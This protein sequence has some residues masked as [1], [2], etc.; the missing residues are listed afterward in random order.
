MIIESVSEHY[1]YD[2]LDVTERER[3]YYRDSTVR[4]VGWET[5]VSVIYVRGKDVY[6]RFRAALSAF[7]QDEKT[8][9][10]TV[11]HRRAARR[12]CQQEPYA[13][14]TPLTKEA[15]DERLAEEGL[16]QAYCLS[17]GM[18]DAESFWY[19]VRAD[20]VLFFMKKLSS[21]RPSNDATIRLFDGTCVCGGIGF[22]GRF[23]T[24][25]ADGA[26]V[27]EPETFDR[28]EP[29][30]SD[31]PCSQYPFLTL[32]RQYAVVGDR[33]YSYSGEYLEERTV[34]HRSCGQVIGLYNLLHKR[35]K[36]LSADHVYMD[37]L[38]P[39]LAGVTETMVKDVLL[40]LMRA[41]GTADPRKTAQ[42]NTL[43]AHIDYARL[44]DSFYEVLQRLLSLNADRLCGGTGRRLCSRAL[45]AHLQ[46]LRD[47]CSEAAFAALLSDETALR[48][49]IRRLHAAY[50]RERISCTT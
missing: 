34:H 22:D 5:P 14:M 30:P 48:T 11:R 39:P 40:P 44:S 4:I 25:A 37:I 19:P 41:E 13:P 47:T 7:E 24:K 27:S 50:R 17:D 36:A 46:T 29:W 20:A 35:A 2:G 32:Y 31:A 21:D 6:L 1:K 12:F 3:F 28:P 15:L 45:L 42:L 16:S 8:D 43:I 9:N 26:Y 38:L 10:R 33:C 49:E 23:Y 18:D